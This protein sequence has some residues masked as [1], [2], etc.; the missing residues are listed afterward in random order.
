MSYGTR[1]HDRKLD[2]IRIYEISLSLVLRDANPSV[3][4]QHE[5]SYCGADAQTLVAGL[6]GLNPKRPKRHLRS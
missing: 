2:E 5:S 1:P 6:C 4:N 3:A